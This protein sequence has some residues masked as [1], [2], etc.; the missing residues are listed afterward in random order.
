MTIKVQVWDWPL[1]L[2]HWLLVLAVVGSYVTGKLGGS[3]TDWHGRLGG[4]V[5]GLL[6]F[7]LIWGFIGSTHARFASFF[8]TYPRLIAYLKGNWQ[9]VGH[10]PIGALAVIALLAIL[11]FMVVTG[12]FAN[13]DIA[14]EGPLYSL[15]DKEFSDKLSGLHLK[16]VNA[17]LVLVGL[18]VA[19]I[20]FYQRVK[21]ADLVLPML[22]GKKQLPKTLAPAPI[23]PVGVMRFAITLLISV[24]IV[25]GVWGGGFSQY[26]APLAGIQTASANA[27]T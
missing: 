3:L 11:L 18:H 19:A 8:P 26:L 20:I 12:L 2:F 17:L 13:D 25:W 4:L 9:G 6:I 22:T 14:F 21:K 16:A 10:N 7:R 24:S 23:K 1:R 15:I 5:L 27:K